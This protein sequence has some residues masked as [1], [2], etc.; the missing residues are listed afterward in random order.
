MGDERPERRSAR[1]GERDGQR[2]A[3][4]RHLFPPTAS[5]PS[6]ATMSS[7]GYSHGVPITYPLSSSSPPVPQPRI[8]PLLP[9]TV[10]PPS[11]SAGS[12]SFPRAFDPDRA[13]LYQR[14]TSRANPKRGWGG[15]VVTA[16]VWVGMACTSL[17]FHLCF[18]RA[19]CLWALPLQ[20]PLLSF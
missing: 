16:V 13:L 1:P 15:K 12:L 2:G 3:A 8:S 17:S 20:L 4:A 6:P 9:P 18:G 10:H 7:E 11:A 14:A 5:A 19:P